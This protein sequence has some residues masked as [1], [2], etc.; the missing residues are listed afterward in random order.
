MNCKLCSALF[1]E[2]LEDSPSEELIVEVQDHI[3]TCSKC[4]VSLRTYTLT[5]TLSR[6]VDPPCCVSPETL[7]RLKKIIRERLLKTNGVPV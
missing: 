3:R 6:K 5:V 1:Q 7:D 2:F 4:R